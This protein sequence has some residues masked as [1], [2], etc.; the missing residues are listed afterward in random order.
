[1]CVCVCVHTYTYTF[2]R[3]YAHTNIFLNIGELAF[4]LAF[5]SLETPYKVWADPERVKRYIYSCTSSYICTL[6]YIYA[7]TYTHLYM[8]LLM[9]T[10]VNT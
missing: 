3:T 9:Y 8:Y 2:L 5:Q 6:T 4:T 10:Y 7:Y 1:M